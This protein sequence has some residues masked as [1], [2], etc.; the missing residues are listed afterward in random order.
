MAGGITMAVSDPRDWVPRNPVAALEFVLAGSVVEK[1]AFGHCISGSYE[2]DLR[3]WRMGLDALASQ[4]PEDIDKLLS[5]PFKE[6]VTRTERWVTATGS[7]FA[8]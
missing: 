2:G 1:G 5:E 4:T 6:V 7:I 3:V 8:A